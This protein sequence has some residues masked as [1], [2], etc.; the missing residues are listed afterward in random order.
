MDVIVEKY[1][2]MKEI[3]KHVDAFKQEFEKRKQSSEFDRFDWFAY[4]EDNR[5]LYT[6][7]IY[8]RHGLYRH[9]YKERKAREERKEQED[10]E[11][12]QDHNT[13]Y[14][15][16]A[17]KES[18]FSWEYYLFFSPDLGKHG[19][20]DQESAVKHWIMHGHKENRQYS[21]PEFD[22]MFYIFYNSLFNHGI[23]TKIAALQYWLLHKAEY[24]NSSL[25]RFRLDYETM[26]N[27]KGNSNTCASV[28][29]NGSSSFQDPDTMSI[30]DEC[31]LYTINQIGQIE[32][33]EFLSRP[34]KEDFLNY[35]S[36]IGF[37]LILDLPAYGG[38]CSF[39]LNTILSKYKT[40]AKCLV[41]RNYS[42]VVSWTLNDESLIQVC[43]TEEMNTAFLEQ[44]APMI[45][46]VFVNSIIGHSS[47]FL[48]AVGQL[49]KPITAITHDYSLLYGQEYSQLYY[50]K[51]LEH[52]SYMNTHLG[53]IDVLLSQDENTL[54]YFYIDLYNQKVSLVGKDSMIIKLP[55]YRKSEKIITQPAKQSI[56]KKIVIGIL[57]HISDIKGYYVLTKIIELV[58][59]YSDELDLVIFGSCNICWPKQ[60]LYQNVRDL[61]RL[62]EEFQPQLWI[63]MSLWPETY[64]YT[65]S[66]VM[67]TQ[68]P[69]L[70]QEKTFS[71]TIKARLI[72]YKKS[73]GFD[74]IDQVTL[75]YIQSIAQSFFYTIEPT[76]YYPTYWDEYFSD[77]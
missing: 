65:L 75:N 55:D 52:D 41:V 49:R 19:I 6:S 71:S 64:S 24:I 29:H 43:Q 63:E 53:Q 44:M 1:A 61:N 45:K 18:Q 57:G 23:T 15:L 5:E 13:N 37:I 3:K 7:G 39:F 9:W 62:L 33:K 54:N 10:R 35:G 32:F 72:E 70:Y 21:V 69:I 46:K 25:D 12:T 58:E 67:A 42:G 30:L 16:T 22:W 8:T 2:Q 31:E 14:I 48:E 4:L 28:L 76:I 77:V 36:Q 34:S 73:Y 50:H 40:T 17:S 20:Q 27:M 68:L 66:L 59:T 47:T 51:M 38:G 60:Y 26:C 56:K 11:E 74:H